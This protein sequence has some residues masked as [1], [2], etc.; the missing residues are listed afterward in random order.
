M[1]SYVRRTIAI[2][3]E[4]FEDSQIHSSVFGD[5]SFEVYCTGESGTWYFKCQNVTEETRG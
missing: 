1:A 4:V 3:P 5:V 2:L